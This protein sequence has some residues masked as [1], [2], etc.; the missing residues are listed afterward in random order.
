MHIRNL[1]AVMLMEGEYSRLGRKKQQ[2]FT[3]ECEMSPHMGE[4][5]VP[6]WPCFGRPETL[7]QE[8]SLA[9][10]VGEAIRVTA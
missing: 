10:L 4:H 8:E 1:K 2:L 3:L 5:L 7:E 6:R 9:K